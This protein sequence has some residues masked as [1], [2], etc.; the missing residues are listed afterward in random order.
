MNLNRIAALLAV[1]LLV[2]ALG[3]NLRGSD[4]GNDAPGPRDDE[5]FVFG[6]WFASGDFD[7]CLKKYDKDGVEDTLDWDK[8]IDDDSDYSSGYQAMDMDSNGNIYIA[9][10]SY[11]TPTGY[12]WRIKKFDSSGVEDTVNWDKTFDGSMNNGNDG[13]SA[14]VVDHSDNVYVVGVISDGSQP[15]QQDWCI[16]KYSADGT[17]ITTGWPK[18]IDGG[19]ATS[20]DLPFAAAVD[21][22]NNLYV[23]G[24][25]VGAS[26]VAAVKKY[27]A[28]GVEDT[29]NWDK[30]ITSSETYYCLFVDAND[31]VFV[32]GKDLSDMRIRKYSSSGVEDTVGWD[33]TIDVG[34]ADQ[35]RG[36]A[37]DSDGNLYFAGYF[38]N[39]ADD[40]WCIKKFSSAG[41]EITSGWDKQFDSGGEDRLYSIAV[42]GV[43]DVYVLGIVFD[44]G[45]T[46]D[47]A[48]KKYSADGVEDTTNWDKSIGAMTNSDPGLAIAV[49]Y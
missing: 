13:P 10:Q 26:T 2:L 21:S 39:G 25:L 37:A 3:C 38:G 41:T 7:V 36:I 18:I 16:K 17:E 19:A 32:G 27:S 43:D 5:I 35:I 34:T 14:L 30:A 45:A 48:I 29:L 49:D 22:A 42:G 9:Y 15:I 4:P 24:F 44:G 40:D 23:T 8:V 31:S 20:P 6:S 33:K 12:D 46:Y 47:W 11:N 1:G 28:A